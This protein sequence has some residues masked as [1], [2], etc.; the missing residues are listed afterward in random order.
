IVESHPR[1]VGE[2]ALK[3]QAHL[4]GSLEVAMGLETVHPEVLPRLNKGFSLAH[5][6]N[7]ARFLW[8]SGIGVRAFVLLKPPFMNE[9]EGVEWAVKSAE[10]A[11]ECGAE[12][13]SLIP[14]RPGNGALERL[15]E[16]GLFTPPRLESLERV[17]ELAI[18]LRAGRVFADV[19]NLEQFSSC[20]V[21]FE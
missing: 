3:F 14:T 20:G 21:C 19:W 13:V 1:L 7:A 12:V 8:D 18:A 4:H 11:F 2:R 10:F 6:T 9:E 15:M 17:L 16:A 5:F